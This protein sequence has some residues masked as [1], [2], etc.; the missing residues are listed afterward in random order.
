MT[1]TNPFHNFRRQLFFCLA[2]SSAS[3]LQAAVSFKTINSVDNPS[4]N[5]QASAI[6]GGLLIGKT[7]VGNQVWLDNKKLRVASDGTFIIGFGRDAITAELRVESIKGEQQ[8]ESIKIQPRK[9][10]IERVDGLPPG[11]VNPKGEEVL[12]RIRDES[13]I[14][15]KVRARDDD[16]ID[17][18]A[19]FVWPAKGRISGVYGSQRIL[20]GEPKWPHYGLDIAAP[21]GTP[22]VAPASGIVTMAHSDM[23]YSGGTLIIDHGFGLSSTFLHLSKILVKEGEVVKQGSVVAKIGATG[24][25]TGPHLDWRINWFKVRLDAQQLVGEM[26]G[27]KRKKETGERSK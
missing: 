7:D 10:K 15:K 6:Q 16:R 26:P 25:A 27:I 21:T 19:G 23:Y 17:F 22:I 24:R 3:L 11:K 8:I 2:L 13:K 9:Y 18:M 4:D 1:V 12:K 14:I 5:K 20:N